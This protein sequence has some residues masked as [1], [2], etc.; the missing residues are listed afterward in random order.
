MQLQSERQKQPWRIAVHAKS[1][2]LDLRFKA[3][4]ILPISK[5]FPTLPV[6]LNF[7]LNLKLYPSLPQPKR[8]KSQLSIPTRGLSIKSKF[9]L[10]LGKIRHQRS[11]NKAAAAKKTS[12]PRHPDAHFT[13]N[14]SRR[15]AYE[16]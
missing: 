7:N 11:K 15:F 14:Q 4:N 16:V 3:T 13:V 5:L 10:I 12:N 8:S 9:L 1:K 2:Y 6:K